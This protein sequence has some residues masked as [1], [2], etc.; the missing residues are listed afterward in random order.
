MA[1]KKK[2]AAH[3]NHERWLVSYADFITL[4]F[5]FFVVMFASGQTD[6]AKAKQVSEA[7][8][9]A[10]DDGHF[11]AVLSAVLGGTVDNKGK[12]NA[13]QKGPGGERKEV[14]PEPVPDNSTVAELLPSVERLNRELHNEIAEGKLVVSLTGRGLVV[15]LREA[16]FF[17]SGQDQVLP[18]SYPML[19]KIAAAVHDL[20]NPIRLDGH[21]DSI[22]IYNDRFHNNWELSSARAVA[23]LEL[24]HERFAIPEDRMAVG[25]F[26]AT[27][28]VDSNDTEQGRAHNRRVEVVILSMK[29]LAGEPPK[30]NAEATPHH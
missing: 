21:T 28:P 25:G 4:L 17:P 14:K 27:K 19:G 26:A 9:A 30:T 16:A 11:T 29:A 15:S 5:A 22:P 10:L 24:F 13:Q 20:P 7:V 18:G 3:E 6:K 8:Q 12:G 23:I 1:R 2:P